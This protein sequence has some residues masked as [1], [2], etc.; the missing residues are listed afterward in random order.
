MVSFRGCCPAV[1][2]FLTYVR[3]AG[4]RAVIGGG[5]GNLIIGG[6]QCCFLLTPTRILKYNYDTH[7]ESYG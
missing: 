6:R 1:A 4:G 2:L 7:G 3:D 5:L